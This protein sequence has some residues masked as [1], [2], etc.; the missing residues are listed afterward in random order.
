MTQEVRQTVKELGA[1]IAE[2]DP[3]FQQDRLRVKEYEFSNGRFFTANYQI[4]GPY[5]PTQNVEDGLQD[6]A[7]RWPSYTSKDYSGV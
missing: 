7:D 6:N 3:S 4:R 2:A 1:I 5:D